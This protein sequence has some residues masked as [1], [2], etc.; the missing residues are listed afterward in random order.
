M[1]TKM[2]QVKCKRC[3]TIIGK[4]FAVREIEQCNNCCKKTKSKTKTTIES[5]YA[6][7]KKG[8][9]EDLP[10]PYDKVV[11]R[12]SWERN[13]ARVLC[14]QNVNWTYEQKR[15]SFS[16]N[17]NGQRFRRGP[18]I[19]IP[20]FYDE[21]NDVIWEI[22]GFFK[23]SD[24]SKTKRL[25]ALYPAEFAKLKICLSKNNKKGI[26]FYGKMGLDI[27]IYEELMNTWASKIKF[28]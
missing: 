23:A 27:L 15:F 21:T 14:K 24:R 5:R 10:S 11:M 16:Q 13:F 26:A 19:Y 2:F 7:I 18:F 8:P 20:D 3:K 12:S 6:A 9:A 17:K 28:E 1:P 25:K 22:K 4:D